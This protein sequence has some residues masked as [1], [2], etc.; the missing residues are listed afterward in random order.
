[1]IETIFFGGVI[2]FLSLWFINILLQIRNEN[3]KRNE[4][5]ELVNLLLLEE[6]E[7]RKKERESRPI[8]RNKVDLEEL[9]KVNLR[10]KLNE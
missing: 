7:L 6:L 8:V 9:G 3:R 4:I 5:F 10:K 1:M 2:A